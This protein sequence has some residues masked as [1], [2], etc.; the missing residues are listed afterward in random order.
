VTYRLGGVTDHRREE[1]ER[2]HGFHPRFC[3]V[4]RS[5]AGGIDV[6]TELELV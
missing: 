2:V 6:E 5:L 3:P 1:V 4:A